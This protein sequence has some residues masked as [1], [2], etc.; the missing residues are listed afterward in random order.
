MRILRQLLKKEGWHFAETALPVQ[1]GVKSADTPF[2][3]KHLHKTMA[4]YFLLLEGNLR[5]QVNDEIL[6]MKQGDL[7]LVEPGEAHQVLH[8]SP[9]ARLLLLMPAAVANDKVEL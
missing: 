5:L 7:I 3:G 6:E 9:D 2:G 4:E 1:V 8:G